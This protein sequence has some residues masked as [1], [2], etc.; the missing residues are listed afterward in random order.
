M[1][2]LVFLSVA[3]MKED[4]GEFSFLREIPLALNLILTLL[5]NIYYNIRKYPWNHEYAKVKFEQMDLINKYIVNT[6]SNLHTTT[7]PPVSSLLCQ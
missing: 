2:V 3:F 7:H 5:F 6:P 4:S 1:N